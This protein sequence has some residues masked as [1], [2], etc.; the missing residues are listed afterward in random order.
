M[1]EERVRFVKHLEELRSRL[2]LCVIAVAVGF[3]AAYTFKEKIFEWLM[4]PMIRALPG[5]GPQKLVY[6]A[7]HEAFVTHIKVS[8]IAGIGLAMP[9]ILY[10]VW[11]FT[12]PGLNKGE[13]RTFF[14]VTLV[15]T[16]FYSCGVL[17]AYFV[18]FPQA[19]HF[20]T[21]FANDTVTPMISTR[22][23]LSFA[24]QFL[25]A[26][27]IIFELP[28]FIFVLARMGLVSSR[29]L[30]RQRRYAILLIFAV[31]AIL[32]PTP[33]AFTQCMMAGPLL[34]LYE[35]SIWIAHFFGR[36]E[37]RAVIPPERTPVSAN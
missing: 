25:L 30:R 19:F 22:E 33:D 37:K 7:P 21:S 9:V 10:E 18:V 11:R 34:I 26:F 28:I 31:A 5:D 1:P 27:G 12:A 14:P 6:T 3:G 13:R 15:S 17:F 8:L 20:F 32:T 36:T 16:L 35:A 2:L 4:L 23:Y 29:L 24:A